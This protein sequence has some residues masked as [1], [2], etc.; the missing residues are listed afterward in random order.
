MA[1][2]KTTGGR[3]RTVDLGKV[4]R[5]GNVTRLNPAGF[6]WRFLQSVR[7]YWWG[8]LPDSATLYGA[9]APDQ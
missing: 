4:D 3:S 2:V 6:L 5:E 9:P 7:R 1:S 8:V